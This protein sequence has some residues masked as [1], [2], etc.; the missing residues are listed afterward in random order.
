MS[1]DIDLQRRASEAATAFGSL[2]RAQRHRLGM[3]QSK[4]SLITGVGRRLIIELE[5][6][7]STCQLGKSLAVA[8]ALGLDLASA[9][10]RQAQTPSSDLDIP[11]EIPDEEDDVDVP[12][13]GLF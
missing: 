3:S 8:S 9:L 2:I 5:A 7:K 11:P 4:M 13:P 12:S 1:E 6:G 10:N